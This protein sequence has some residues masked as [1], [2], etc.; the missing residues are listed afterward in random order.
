MN[1]ELRSTTPHP[2]ETAGRG[3]KCPR[4]VPEP[5]AGA[6]PRCQDPGGPSIA[7]AHH[8]QDIKI[9]AAGEV[10]LADSM[11]PAMTAATAALSETMVFI[12]GTAL[13]VGCVVILAMH[14]KVSRKEIGVLCAS[15]ASPGTVLAVGIVLQ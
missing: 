4:T 2:Q 12:G 7:I 15:L 1:Q 14:N 10:R 13:L 9:D 6:P 11:N 3:N 5:A 8:G